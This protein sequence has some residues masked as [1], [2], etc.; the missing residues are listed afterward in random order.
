MKK[1]T[2]DMFKLM[3]D[4]IGIAMLGLVMTI[5]TH[6]NDKLYLMTSVLCVAFYVYLLYAMMYDTGKK[7]KPAIDGGRAKL[8]P[9]KGLWIGLGANA[10]NIICGVMI[11]VFS[12]YTVLQSPVV[13]LDQNGNEAKVFIRN[14]VTET[15]DVQD[16]TYTQVELFSNSGGEAVIGE[17]EGY[18]SSEVVAD[19][20]TVEVYDEDNNEIEL[21]SDSGMRL[22]TKQKG[23]EN[24]ASN[25]YGIPYIAATFLQSMFEG[26]RYNF[27]EG[28]DNYFYLLTP[29][30]PILFSAL[31]YYMG[32]KGK[33]ILFF[34][35]E[36][37]QKPKY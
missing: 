10:I 30:L 35:P 20:G 32:A 37:K 3:I 16:Y 23:I 6:T 4:Q 36:R 21:Y 34:L 9:L 27:F 22:S 1:Y 14:E 8:N 28:N 15:M 31:G 2:Y 7:D 19:S 11:A 24:W 5:A 18:R 25:L 17:K 12:A 33:R 26:I 13:V 29:V